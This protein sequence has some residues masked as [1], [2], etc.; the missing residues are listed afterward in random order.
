MNSTFKI[1][2]KT[3]Y[4][5]V[6]GNVGVG[7]STLVAALAKYFS[8]KTVIHTNEFNTTGQSYLFDWLTHLNKKEFPNPSNPGN[9]IEIDLGIEFHNGD[10]DI[11]KIT[12]LEMS[13]E[14]LV[15]I[16][17][18]EN[19]DK[20]FE[21]KFIQ[22]ILASKLFIIVTDPEHAAD[23]DFLIWQFF[24]KLSNNGADMSTLALVIAKWDMVDNQNIK[25]F[26]KKNLPQTSNWLQSNNIE[27]ARV[28]PFSVGSVSNNSIQNLDFNDCKKLG[29]WIYQI[30]MK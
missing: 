29:E 24:N 23:D 25:D 3:N 19:G 14:D 12:F 21:E 15:K 20:Q 10:D 11:L 27:N 28:F 22:Y 17:L 7:K 4:T 16:D 30:L 2:Q 6:F 5:F 8:L 26:V 9:I 1:Q 18:R 13:G